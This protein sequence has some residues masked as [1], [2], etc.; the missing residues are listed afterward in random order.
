MRQNYP[1]SSAEINDKILLSHERLIHL[2]GVSS[3]YGYVS[4][5]YDNMELS[6]F[7]MMDSIEGIPHVA[8][9]EETIGLSAERSTELMLDCLKYDYVFKTYYNF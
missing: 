3:D 8:S 6:G 2:I 1:L 7:N 4:G 5:I 9:N